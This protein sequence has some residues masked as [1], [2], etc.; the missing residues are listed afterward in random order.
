MVGSGALRH[1]LGAVELEHVHDVERLERHLETVALDQRREAR[2]GEVG[3]R[4]R[5]GEIVVD[6]F[7]HGRSSPP[8]FSDAA[9]PSRRRRVSVS[10][11]SMSKAS[12]GMS[13]NIDLT[14]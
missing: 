2:A 11:A 10:Y 4:R 6:L 9:A 3:P 7:G 1:R 14:E 13:G 5:Q 8:G 12:T